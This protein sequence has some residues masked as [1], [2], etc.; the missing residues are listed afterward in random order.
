MV[1]PLLFLLDYKKQNDIDQQLKDWKLELSAHIF[2]LLI[3]VF[4]PSNMNA[5]LVYTG[6]SKFSFSRFRSVDYLIKII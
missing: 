2:Q 6:I 5:F 3:L 4:I 1:I